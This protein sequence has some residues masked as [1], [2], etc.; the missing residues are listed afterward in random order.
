[1]YRS[2]GQYEKTREYYEKA[3]AI[4]RKLGKRQETAMCFQQLASAFFF[5]G[6]YAEANKNNQEGLLIATQIGARREEANF[7]N[8]QGDVYT[9]VGKDVEAKEFFEK[10]LAIS[11]EI[12]DRKGEANNCLKLGTVFCKLGEYVKGEEY[13]R[14]GYAR[15][16]EIGDVEGQLLSLCRL[17]HVRTQE[18]K[19]YEA[20]PYILSAVTKC[21]DLRGCLQDNDQFKISFSDR[22]IHSYQQLSAL[23]CSAGNSYEALYVTELGRASALA[24]LMSTQYSVEKQISANPQTWAGIEK[25][26][27]N[28]RDCTCLYVSY[29]FDTI[30]LWIVKAS[31]DMHFQKINGHQLI[32]KEGLT[33]DLEEFFDSKNFTRFGISQMENTGPKMKLALCYKL[34]IAPVV[35]LL[36]GQEIIIVPDRSLYN[37]PFAALP[38]KDGKCLSETFRIRIVPSL[39]TL[40]LIQNSPADYHSQT[41][42]LIVGNPDVGKVRFKGRLRSI[43]RLPCAENESKMVGKMLGVKPLLGQEATKQAVLEAINSV[44]LIHIAAHGDAEKGEIALAP[45]VRSPNRI[46]REED[47]LLTMADISNCQLR[48]KLVVL[49]CNH[50]ARGQIRA[51]GAVGIARAFLGAGARSV[52]VSLWALEDNATEQLMSR[53]YEHLVGGDSASESLHEA[54]NWMRCN[55]YSHVSQWAPFILIGD[56]VTFDFENQGKFSR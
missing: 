1:M 19:I 46:P 55:G 52:V 6:K 34:L 26:M 7:Y 23:F 18:G 48:A 27:D 32:V 20:L 45:S 39:T 51:E 37:I 30:F 35:D 21:E 8:I 42:A 50:S 12:R 53:F 41:G 16:E 11:K 4:K 31:E 5:L 10:A 40:K 22:H 56:N 54:M 47:Y 38:D 14:G 44:S 3:L 28:E 29:F 13:L 17:A 33:G 15:S 36:G 25:V 24:D 43:S 9:S 2:V 49:S